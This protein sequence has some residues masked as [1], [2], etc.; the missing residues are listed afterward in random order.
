MVIP[1]FSSSECV[2]VHLP[3]S[4]SVK[5][6]F[7]WSTWPTNPMLTSGCTG[8]AFFYVV[9]FLAFGIILLF[10]F[11]KLFLYLLDLFCLFLFY[12]LVTTSFLIFNDMGTM[13]PKM[14]ERYHNCHWHTPFYD[15]LKD[16][17][18]PVDTAW[19]FWI[20]WKSILFRG[21]F[22]HVHDMKSF[23]FPFSIYI[24]CAGW[25]V[26]NLSF[27]LGF[28]RKPLPIYRVGQ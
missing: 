13:E 10:L 16:I 15:R 22:K 23:E 17:L 14:E 20:L 26:N 9:V 19:Y 4:L 24:M 11:F 7:P 3:D 6:V 8:A 28:F 21:F 18:P 5:V 25:K 12:P 2:S 27:L 1:L